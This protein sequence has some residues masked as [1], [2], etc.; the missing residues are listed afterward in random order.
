MARPCEFDESEAVERSMHV[1]WERGFEG[2]A[3]SDLEAATGVKR[4]SLYNKFQSKH[5]LMLR[6]LEHYRN[7][8]EAALRALFATRRPTLLAVREFLEGVLREP[9]P[10]KRR[11][12]MMIN[13]IVEL[14]PSD[15]QMADATAR[16]QRLL[17]RIFAEA[18]REAV[19]RGELASTY[20]CDAAAHFLVGAIFGLRLLAKADPG[21]ESLQAMVQVTLRALQG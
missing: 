17:V 14:A 4:Q 3:I 6:C 2:A 7:E 11:G 10:L 15:V 18:F 8:N 1:F 19:Q 16:H 9:D 20:D 12:C 13:T 21:S 5:A